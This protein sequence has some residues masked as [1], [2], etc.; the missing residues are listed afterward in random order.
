[1]FYI[2]HVEGYFPAGAVD[3]GVLRDTGIKGLIC[4][5]FRI[6]EKKL[7]RNSECIGCMSMENK[8]YL[9]EHNPQIPE[10]KVGI[11]PN[12]IDVVDKCVVDKHEICKNT[13]CQ[14]ISYYYYMVEILVCHK[15]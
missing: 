5:Y 12:T 15:M 10:I 13:I 11:C 8:R 3:L 6:V 2:S 4:R 7:Y 14:R 1:M 9:L